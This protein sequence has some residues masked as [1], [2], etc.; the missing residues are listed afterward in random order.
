VI[1]LVTK[2]SLRRDGEWRVGTIEMPSCR[3]V[4]AGDDIATMACKTTSITG[5]NVALGVSGS[6]VVGLVKEAGPIHLGRVIVL[7]PREADLFI[8]ALFASLDSF[9]VV[10]NVVR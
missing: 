2:S 8:L 10:S 9:K 4:I 5:D 7:C 3:A 6:F 1:G